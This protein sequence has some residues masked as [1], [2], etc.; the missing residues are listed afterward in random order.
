METNSLE[1]WRTI[2]G[3]NLYEVSNLG[4]IRGKRRTIINNKGSYVREPVAINTR[5]DQHGYLQFCMKQD[6]RRK[7][8]KVHRAVAMAF[9]PNPENKPCVNHIDNN[10]ANN[11]LENL[12]WVTHQENTD[13][14]IKQGRFKRTPQWLDRL[15]KTQK[16]R[17]YKPVIATNK[18]TGEE[19]VFESVN[20]TKEKGFEPSCVSTCCNGIRASHKGYTWRF[21]NYGRKARYEKSR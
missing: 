5:K 12:E 10:P 17:Q 3:W 16:E 14:M 21:A 8:M 1:I 18:K 4:N 6:G 9:I 7:L 11:H 13:W 15:H 20:S 2:P 19:I